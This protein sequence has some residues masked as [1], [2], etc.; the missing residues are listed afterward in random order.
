MYVY[1]HIYKN[2]P[3]KTLYV[4][5]RAV[6][7]LTMCSI[8]SKETKVLSRNIYEMYIFYIDV[9]TFQKETYIH[10]LINTHTRVSIY[11]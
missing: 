3:M 9:L 5:T 4:C 6:S 7:Y 8:I 11:A 1:A 2:I 10:K